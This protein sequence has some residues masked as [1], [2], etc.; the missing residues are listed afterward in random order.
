MGG[1]ETIKLHRSA[2]FDTEKDS[3]KNNLNVNG[4][5]IEI[6]NGNK[7][8][9]SK[10][11]G[12]ETVNLREDS[13]NLMNEIAGLTKEDGEK[14]IT[15]TE[16]DFEAF[17]N[18]YENDKNF[19]NE[20]NKKYNLAGIDS[21]KEGMYYMDFKDSSGSPDFKID[22]QTK[23]EKAAIDAENKAKKDA[24]VKAQAEKE[25]KEK[26][27]KEAWIKEN[28]T[29]WKGVWNFMKVAFEDLMLH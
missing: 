7:Y 11:Y 9:N 28:T 13:F 27:E 5:R 25:A 8:E 18:K 10:G 22:F 23:E 24:E 29:G 15:L 3:P 26:A 21:N 2:S 20:I 4:N 6:W 1:V 17:K 14:E 19:R 16:K 12:T